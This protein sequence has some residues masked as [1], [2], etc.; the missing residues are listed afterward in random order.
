MKMEGRR[1]Y[2]KTDDAQP[3]DD[4]IV[5]SLLADLQEKHDSEAEMFILKF[6]QQ[7]RNST[8]KMQIFTLVCFIFRPMMI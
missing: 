4:H 5:V 2:L 7:V 8:L 1:L 3:T 6:S